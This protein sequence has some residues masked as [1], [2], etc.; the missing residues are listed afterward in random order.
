MN[1]VTL[2]G[3]LTKD[4]ELIDLNKND[5]K[6]I[7]FILAVDKNYKNSNGERETDFIPIA[8]FTNYYDRLIQYLLKGALIAV[9]GELSISSFKK[10]DGTKTYYTEVLADN[11]QFLQSKKNMAV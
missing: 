5:R 11:I 4:A 10:Q 2:V 8:Y 9:S 7:K 1:K 3:R 6:G